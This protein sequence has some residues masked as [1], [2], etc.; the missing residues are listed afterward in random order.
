MVMAHRPESARDSKVAELERQ[1]QRC[2]AEIATVEKMLYAEHPD[3]EGLCMALSDWSAELR[4]L[5]EEQRRLGET[6]RR[7]E[8]GAGDPQALTE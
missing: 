5:Q 8:D 2:N 4:I 1:I 7:V 3:V 6:R